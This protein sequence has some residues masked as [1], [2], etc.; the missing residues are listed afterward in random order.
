MEYSIL[1]SK[2]KKMRPLCIVGRATNNGKMISFKIKR[3]VGLAVFCVFCTT[4]LLGQNFKSD[5]NALRKKYA[6]NLSMKITTQ[7]VSESKDYPSIT[8]D[9]EIKVQGKNM[10][11]RQGEDEVVYTQNYMVVIS[12]AEKS[13]I[14]DTATEQYNAAPLQYANLDSMVENYKS[15]KFTQQGS[16]KVYKIVPKDAGI[17]EI[18]IVLSSDYTLQKMKVKLA[19]EEGG[20]TAIISYSQQQFNPSFSAEFS[21][22]SYVKKQGDNFVGAGK[23]ASYT[24]ENSY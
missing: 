12:N 6:G 15:V 16:N 11:Y 19:A 23:Y 21:L 8:L 10:Y 20:G 3:I 7:I 18:E 9:G 17:S 4:V 22:E 2:L 13:L 5:I 14:V 24:L 1:N